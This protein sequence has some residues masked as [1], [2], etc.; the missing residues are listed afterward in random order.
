MST[1]LNDSLAAIRRDIENLHQAFQQDEVIRQIIV[2]HLVKY[3]ADMGLKA[4]PS[5]K[6]PRS[7]RDRIDLVGAVPEAD[8][9]EIKVA[10]AVDPLV[11]LPKIKAMEWVSCEEK[12]VVTYSPRGDKVSQSTF[13]L[14]SDMKHIN[15]FE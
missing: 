8:P 6:P 5:W 13:F 3:L 12:V 10:F 14:S 9:P 4:V 2:S 15:L 11:E 1:D 7:T